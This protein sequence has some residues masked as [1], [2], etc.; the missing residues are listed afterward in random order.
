MRAGVA[1]VLAAL[2]V[3]CTNTG[4]DGDTPTPRPSPEREASLVVKA[5]LQSFN[6]GEHLFVLVLDQHGNVVLRRS[7]PVQDTT[8]RAHATVA[9]GTYQLLWETAP[10]SASECAE[11]LSPRDLANRSTD[12][13][14]TQLAFDAND[15]MTVVVKNPFP[16]QQTDGGCLASIP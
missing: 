5:N 15:S 6:A 13:C 8:V 14:R 3:S 2:T 16:G 1:V 10:C 7:F 4:V 12:V 11:L 9:D